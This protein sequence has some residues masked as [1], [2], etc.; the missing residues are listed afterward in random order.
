MLVFSSQTIMHLA[1]VAFLFIGGT[2]V[3]ATTLYF[4]GALNSNHYISFVS[5][6]SEVLFFL[7]LGSLLLAL[8]V[9]LIKRIRSYESSMIR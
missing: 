2:I 9:Y 7:A 4:I 1:I 6:I 3:F 5:I 8:G